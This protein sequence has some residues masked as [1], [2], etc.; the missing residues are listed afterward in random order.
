[1]LPQGNWPEGHQEKA[2]RLLDALDER[3]DINLTTQ[4]WASGIVI[5]SKK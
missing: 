5:A 4:C 1:M 2:L 3:T